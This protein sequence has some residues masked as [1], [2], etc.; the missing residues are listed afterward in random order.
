MNSESFA[1]KRTRSCISPS[2][3]TVGRALLSPC[4]RALEST[5]N[6]DYLNLRLLRAFLLTTAPGLQRV[7]QALDALPPQDEDQQESI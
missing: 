6:G 1:L 3:R 2:S 4:G 7:P 5:K